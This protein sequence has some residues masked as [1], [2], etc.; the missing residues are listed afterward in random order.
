MRTC[1]GRIQVAP[2]YPAAGI[3]DAEVGEQSPLMAAVAEAVS[4]SQ[5]F[6]YPSLRRSGGTIFGT[7][8]FQLISWCARLAAVPIIVTRTQDGAIIT[9][10][11]DFHQ[12][13]DAW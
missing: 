10:V 7:A 13:P 4:G 8:R 9:V 6:H 11:I 3:E 12:V 5:V 2:A 1:G